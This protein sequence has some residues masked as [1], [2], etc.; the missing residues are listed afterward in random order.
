MVSVVL[1]VATEVSIE[2]TREVLVAAQ[3]DRVTDTSAASFPKVAAMTTGATPDV[4]TSLR[5]RA[6][7]GKGLVEQSIERLTD[8]VQI[9]SNAAP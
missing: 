4:Q 8:V 9:F 2:G 7:I 5:S 6:R 3:R 1:V